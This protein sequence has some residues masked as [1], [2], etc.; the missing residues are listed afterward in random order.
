MSNIKIKSPELESSLKESKERMISKFK[1]L[2]IAN[3]D[4]K[5]KIKMALCMSRTT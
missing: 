1:E 4:Q 3:I 2:K 5:Q